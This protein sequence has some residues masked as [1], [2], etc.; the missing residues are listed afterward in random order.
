MSY[1]DDAVKAKL[2]ALNETQEAIVTVAQW[3]MFHRKYAARTA[4]L[5]LQR[6]KESLAPKRLNLLYLA[7]EVV[8]QSKARK[9]VDFLTA[10]APIIAE[11]TA[12]AYKG[13]TIDIQQK[14]RRVVEVWR[15]RVIFDPPIQQDIEIRI[16]EIDRAR[17]VGK[18]PALGGSL[19]SAAASSA[20]P[21][22]QALLTSQAALSKSE[23]LATPAINTANTDYDKHA[24]PN[25]PVPTPP[26]QAARLAALLKTLANAEGA[27]AESIKA[28]KTLITGLEKLLEKNKE[29][30][31][32]EESQLYTINTRKNE[33][34]SQRQAVEEAIMRGLSDSNGGDE[35]Q[36]PEAEPLTPPM[37]PVESITP[38]GTPQG[39]PVMAS[40][41]PEP[42]RLVLGQ[43]MP[44]VTSGA[45]KRAPSNASPDEPYVKSRKVS[46]V[47]E[48]DEFAEFQGVGGIDADVEAL[49]Q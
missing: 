1:T 28:R 33:I 22:Y 11:A 18:R 36:R 3:I 41:L 7:N 12:I 10:F 14:I 48:V 40:R 15:Q 39:S 30:L 42:E 47:M 19:F 17:G 21:E 38:T 45:L 35:P 44:L 49:L 31:S 37:P 8:Q 16:D 9:K 6:L 32:T 4:E 5:W 24:D 46:G 13:A 27:V 20:P 25:T 29:I 23:T 2:S 26:V 34:S 43:G